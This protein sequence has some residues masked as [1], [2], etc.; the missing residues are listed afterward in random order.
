[1]IETSGPQSKYF[2][3][4]DRRQRVVSAGLLIA[5]L[6][7]VSLLWG[8]HPS[9]W[10][11]VCPF[12]SVSGL[13]CPGC[14]SLRST[15]AMLNGDFGVGFRTNPLMMLIGVPLGSWF[16]VDQFFVVFGRKRMRP[17]FRSSLV[18]W[19]GLAL[20]IAFFVI[21]NMPIER[22]DFLRPENSSLRHSE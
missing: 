17:L 21:R 4:V 3:S 2:Y 7:G 22:L 15:H 5:M 6:L 16:L 19:A 9:G 20:L 14:G 8:W 10:I 18:A 1:M 11:P 13:Y 12:W